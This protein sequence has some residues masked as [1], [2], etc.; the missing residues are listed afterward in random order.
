[1][2][3][4]TAIDSSLTAEVVAAAVRDAARQPGQRRKLAWAL[5]DRPGLLTGDGAAAPVAAVLRLIDA[6][7]GSGATMIVRP[8]CPG[9]RQVKPLAGKQGE[10]RVCASCSA[11]ARAVAC[12]RCGHVRPACTRDA[13]GRPVCSG[14]QASDPVN[15]EPCTG[16]GQMRQVTARTAEGPWCHRCRPGRAAVCG[17]CGQTRACAIS[18][19]TGQPWCASCRRWRAR[20]A[21]C[22]TVAP[23]YA[24]TRER[25]LCARCASPD[26]GSWKRCPACQQTWQLGTRPCQQCALRR[27]ITGRLS[28]GTGTISS[29]LAPLHHALTIVE[30]PSTVRTWLDL[31][32][33]RTL[34]TSLSQDP[35]PLTH[36]ILDEFPASSTLA[37]LRSILV[38]T[39][40]LPGRDERL[41]QLER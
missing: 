33:V 16:C 14:C 12:A 10:L 37:H 23:V 4:V 40:A 9:C 24:G 26:P 30:R 21:G 41:V 25:P 27:K 13:Q 8:A 32:P 38:A 1:V 36:E 31:P 11:R 35:R 6:L 39:S 2:R 34:L 20:C 3:V 5:Q 19:V 22:G 18:Q 28:D 29:S 7:A 17:I 15:H